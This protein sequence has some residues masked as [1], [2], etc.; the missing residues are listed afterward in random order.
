M[1]EAGDRIV[2]CYFLESGMASLLSTTESGDTVEVGMVGNEG[3]VGAALV[4]DRK[5]VV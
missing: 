4:L 2:E 1:F 5:S 3:F